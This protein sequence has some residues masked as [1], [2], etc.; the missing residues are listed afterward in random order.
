MAR[1]AQEFMREVLGCGPERIAA[2]KG[3][4]VI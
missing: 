1:Y 3:Q 4:E 2:L